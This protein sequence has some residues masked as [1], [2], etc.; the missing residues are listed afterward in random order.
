[1]GFP[2]GSDSKFIDCETPER[3]S[4]QA[5]SLISRLIFTLY[6]DEIHFPPYQCLN[7]FMPVCMLSHIGRVQLFA[8]LWTVVGQAPLSIGL[9]RQKYWSG[10]PC[11]PPGDSPTH[12]RRTLLPLLSYVSCIGGRVLYH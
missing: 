10:L 4:H 9:S 2:G 1:M 5:L 3:F 7:V 12:K 6:K 8:A 11:S